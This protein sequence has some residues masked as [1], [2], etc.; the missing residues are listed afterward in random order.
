MRAAFRQFV[1]A[2]GPNAPNFKGHSGWPG[3]DPYST[4]LENL[5]A[6]IGLHLAVIAGECGIE[7]GPD[8][9]PVLPPDASAGDGQ[10][11]PPGRDE[12]LLPAR[13]GQ[14]LLGCH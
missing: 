3:M 7:I 1:D 6:L 12:P 11:F 13:A 5:R 14:I 2:A 4:A 10:S 9:A 8:L